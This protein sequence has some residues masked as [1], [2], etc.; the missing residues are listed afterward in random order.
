LRTPRWE[1]D[2]GSGL[3]DLPTPLWWPGA[4][5]FCLILG[6]GIKCLCHW[7][8]GDKP[9]QGR[10]APCVEEQCDFCADGDAQQTYFYLP[11]Q[12]YL[13]NPESGSNWVK[14]I[15][16]LSRD[17]REQLEAIKT[18]KKYLR[19]LV[20]QVS[21]RGDKPKGPMQVV[22]CQNGRDWVQ[23]DAFDVR[24]VLRKWWARWLRDPSA[25]HFQPFLPFPENTELPKAVGGAS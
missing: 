25:N 6:S 17:A 10:I 18:A 22:F 20:V 11:V 9:S 19:G 1:G 16:C 13:P 5:S 2:A 3:P 7:S 23:I 14:N 21:R 12:R 4:P 8:E 24:P 15:L